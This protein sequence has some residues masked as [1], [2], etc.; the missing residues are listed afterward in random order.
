M[1]KAF[2]LF[3]SFVLVRYFVLAILKFKSLISKLFS[4][5]KYHAL[6][7]D[8]NNSLCHWTTEI[9]YGSNVSVGENSRIGP[10]CTLGAKSK[11]TIGKNVVVSKNVT[12]ETAGLDLKDVPP[13]RNHISKDITIGDGVWIG[14]NS[15]ILS[16]VTIGN[17]V[18]IGAGTVVTKDIPENVIVVGNGNR[19]LTK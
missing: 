17:N 16:G 15:I 3:C 7:Q 18:I 1:K 9:K 14:S 4:N 8:S 6:V 10:N 5:L 13:Y 11:I 2:K 19:I 12:I